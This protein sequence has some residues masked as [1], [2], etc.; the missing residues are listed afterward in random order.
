MTE[1]EIQAFRKRV[2]K[3][4]TLEIARCTVPFF[5]HHN[6]TV[7][8]N[9]TG[10]LLEIADRHFVL[11]A[12]H[13]LDHATIHNIPHYLP[14]SA[15]GGSLIH[16][17]KVRAY[18]T[19]VP[20]NRVETDP[21]MRNDDP[22]DVGVVE[23]TPEIAAL[24]LPARRFARLHELDKRKGHDQ[25]MYMVIGYPR[26]FMKMLDA[27]GSKIYTEPL[28]CVTELHRGELPDRDPDAHIFLTYP[29]EGIDGEDNPYISPHA[30]GISGGGIWRLADSTKPAELWKAEDAKLVAIE[31]SWHAAKRYV[32]GTSVAMALALIYGYNESLRP[33]LDMDY[34]KV[35]VEWRA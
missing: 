22:N 7:I 31:H 16:L 2:V 12:A 8:S 14:P 20:R 35:E 13:V 15:N 9:G 26:A 6:G 25:A 5:A 29:K 19:P 4:C 21:E 27:E 28:R 11:T 32:R 33:I 1:D 17:N 18:T 23:L 3:A 24:L 34:G 30:I 10:T